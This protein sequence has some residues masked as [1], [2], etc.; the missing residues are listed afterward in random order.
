MRPVRVE[1]GVRLLTVRTGIDLTAPMERYSRSRVST[2]AAEIC[3]A[4]CSR[5][6]RP[7]A[8]SSG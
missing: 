3:L 4:T 5:K 7:A 8:D 6:I 1:N 2:L